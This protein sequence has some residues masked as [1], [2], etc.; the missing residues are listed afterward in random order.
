[1]TVLTVPA[2][3]VDA[4]SFLTMGKAFCALATGNVLFPSFGLAGEGDV[5]VARP[6]IAIGAFMAGAAVA[7]VVLTRLAE[8]GRPWF[9]VGLV[10]EAVLLVCAG[11]PALARHGTGAVPAQDDRVALVA[12]A[13]GVRAST[14]LRVHVPGMPTLLSQTAIA[15]LV[16]DVLRRH[17]AALCGMTAKQRLAR[18]RW[19]ATVG[20][21]FSGGVL[22]T[23][24]LVPL[25]TGRALLV[26]AAAVLLLAVVGMVAPSPVKEPVPDSS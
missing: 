13:M 11:A 1:M 12:P 6:A 26:I 23:L 21:I 22:G 9:P 2:G 7:G 25:D 20:G 8:R 24:L 16:N 10:C 18:T 5:P 15:E 19:T 3:A 14:V 17:R 4:V